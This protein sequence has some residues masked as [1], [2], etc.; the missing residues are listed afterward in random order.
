MDIAT[1]E[2]ACMRIE[3]DNKRLEKIN[4]KVEDQMG[5]QVNVKDRQKEIAVRDRNG[6]RDQKKKLAVEFEEAKEAKAEMI[7]THGN[8]LS[9]LSLNFA[10]VCRVDEG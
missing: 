10:F 1:I 6:V 5:T 4:Q 7:E 3:A 2:H 8:R 9:F